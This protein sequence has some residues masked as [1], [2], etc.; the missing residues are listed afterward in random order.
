MLLRPQF[1][2]VYLH[3][4]QGFTLMQ[5]A[6][7]TVR[8]VVS[9][10]ALLGTGIWCASSRLPVGAEVGAKLKGTGHSFRRAPDTFRLATWNIHGGKGPDSVVDLDRIARRVASYDFVGLNEVRGAYGW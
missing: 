2:A 9:L 7:R 10:L 6:Y 1:P 5:Q 8:I 4:N 3:T